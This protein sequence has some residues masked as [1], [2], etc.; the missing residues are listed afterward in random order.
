MLMGQLTQSKEH[1]VCNSWLSAEHK[2]CFMSSHCISAVRN[3]HAVHRILFTHSSPHIHAVCSTHW[4]CRWSHCKPVAKSVVTVILLEQPSLQEAALFGG[5]V[6]VCHTPTW[7][8]DLIAMQRSTMTFN[9]PF[10]K[11][12]HHFLLTAHMHTQ[13]VGDAELTSKTY[14]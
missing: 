14:I 3:A 10:C 7:I 8:S 4:C 2:N 6:T 5:R 12:S 13:T 9:L 11:P 1:P